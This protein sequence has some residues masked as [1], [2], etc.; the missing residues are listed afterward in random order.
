VEIAAMGMAPMG[1]CA[2]PRASQAHL[3]SEQ[4]IEL[5]E[6]NIP[7]D[8]FSFTIQVMPFASP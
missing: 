8:K 3:V 4:Y 7:L 1:Y 2:S 6:S 5:V